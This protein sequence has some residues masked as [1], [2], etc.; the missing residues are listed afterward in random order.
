MTAPNEITTDV[1]IDP[2]SVE[3]IRNAFESIAAQMNNNLIRSAYTPIIYEMKDCAVALYDARGR[4]LGQSTGLPIF[5]GALDAAID[6]TIA[7]F[8]IGYDIFAPG[9]VYAVND[10]YLVGS[11]LNDVS[12]FSP[13]FYKGA[14]VGFGAS[15][16]HWI[17]IGAKDPSQAVDSTSIYQ[18]GYRLGPT[19]I[20]RQGVRQDGII[21][22]LLRN[23]RVPRSIHGDMH[24]QV[25]AAH[26][27]E[28]LLG[29]LYDRFGAQT[30]ETAIE[31]IFRQCETLSAEVVRE[32]P[33]GVYRAEGAL[34]SWGPG[35]G[36][37]P[38]KVKIT[39]SDEDIEL[40]LRGSSPQTPGSMNCGY[41]QTVSAARLAFKFLIRPDIP[42][43]DGTFR[44]LSIKTDEA[45]VFDARE[46][47]ACQFYYPHLGMMIDLVLKA[48][49]PALP[50]AVAA[51]QP[52]DS[53]NIFMTGFADGDDERFVYG[54]AT[55]VGWGAMSDL[56]G[57]SGE[58]NYGGGDLKN[59]PI[60][61]LEARYPIRIHG[62]G[63]RE[64]SGGVG[65]H[66]GG[67]GVW[68]DYE[69]LAERMTVSLWF[70]R[71]DM[72]AWGLF[73]GGAGRPTTVELDRGEGLE[74]IL[75]VNQLAVPKGTRI[76]IM[77][78][79]GGGYGPAEERDPALIERDLLDGYV[80]DA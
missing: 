71:G 19:Q 58:I 42:A 29:K 28:V 33:N 65:K 52:A 51:G 45:S 6:A 31:E 39:V 49:A 8:G 61:V 41:P 4:L 67:L 76:K 10:S 26:T 79:G 34:D 11:H 32:I 77:T 69:T 63:Y 68:R 70:E 27:G 15:K 13:L 59:L 72:P 73:G 56:D 53:M 21:D 18:E 23:S 80:T 5:L 16:A 37:V 47:A 22:L 50:D 35:G 1:M 14:L 30:I 64:G 20:Y 25:V 24:A 75:K 9:D 17:D 62:Y 74:R 36:P 40:D 54:E 44:Y 46:P 66:R 38:V 2:V 48:L 12:V 60:E 57:A 78:G 43:T 7:H 3:V 55:A